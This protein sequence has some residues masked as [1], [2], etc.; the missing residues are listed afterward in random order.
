M[1]R[2]L[3]KMFAGIHALEVHTPAASKPGAQTDAIVSAMV[4]KQLETVPFGT[5]IDVGSDPRVNAW[6]SATEA[7]MKAALIAQ[8][9]NA[10]MSS[11]EI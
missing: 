5:S 3:P 9:D 4:S 7:A 2:H 6:L 10:L 1:Q 11:G 8:L